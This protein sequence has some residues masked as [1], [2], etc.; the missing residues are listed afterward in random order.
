VR[1]LFFLMLLASCATGSEDTGT[2]RL[3]AEETCQGVGPVRFWIDDVE[4][5]VYAMGAGNT[6]RFSVTAGM[7]SFRAQGLETPFLEFKSVAGFVSSDRTV[8]YR[9]RCFNYLHSPGT[10]R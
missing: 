2:V 8:I 1:R 7:H 9:L 5:G 6:Y 4:Q 3:D 10:V